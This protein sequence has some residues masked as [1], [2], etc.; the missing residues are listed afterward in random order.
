MRIL[1]A[2]VAGA[3]ALLGGC[4]HTPDPA[5]HSQASQLLP[6][7]WILIAP[8][9]NTLTVAFLETFEFLPDGKDRFPGAPKRMTEQDRRSLQGL[10]EQV[11]AAPTAEAR[12]EIL[13]EL[14]AETE[15]P[16]EQWRRVRVFKSSSACESTRAELVKVTSEQSQKVGAYAGMPR[17]EFQWPLLARS[18]QWSRCVPSAVAGPQSQS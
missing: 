15:A 6:Q 16:I 17:E 1:V 2:L 3:A 14:S 9:D 12:L 7:D 8:P 13:T 11:K 18:F 5:R 4:S 10:F